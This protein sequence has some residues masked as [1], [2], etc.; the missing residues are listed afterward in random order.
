MTIALQTV[1]IQATMSCNTIRHNSSS[2]SVVIW[3]GLQTGWGPARVFERTVYPSR[4][5]LATVRGCSQSVKLAPRFCD[6]CARPPGVSGAY[7]RR[8]AATVVLYAS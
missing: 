4:L 5:R 2:R 7:L 1:M 3:W 6:L 8:L